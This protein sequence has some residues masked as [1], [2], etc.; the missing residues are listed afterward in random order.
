MNI[1]KIVNDV[2]EFLKNNEDYENMK[3]EYA[4][5][6]KDDSNDIT[7]IACE[8]EEIISIN[9]DTMEIFPVAE[10]AYSFDED[11]LGELES[12]KEIAY[13][14]T[15]YHY[16]IWCGIEQYFPE[17]IEHKEGMQIY[18]Q[19][20][21]DKGITKKYLDEKTNLDTPNIMQHFEGLAFRETMQYKGYTIEAD[22]TNIDNDKENI[23]QIY[24]NEQDYIN[25][26]GREI[27]SLNTVGLKQNIKDY[28]D[29]NYQENNSLD[30]EKA[31]F[32]FVLG[33]DVLQ[34]MFKNS[35]SPECDLVYDFCN[36]EADQFLKSNEYQDLR[37][38]GYE[39]LLEW[40]QNNKEKIMEDFKEMT[41][42]EIEI[43]NGNM[44]II[45]R[46]QR[47]DQPIALVEKSIGNEKEY[48]VAFY[49]KTNGDKL[50]WGYGY[51]YDNDK[52][53]ALE[54]YQ[55]VISGG[56]ITRTFERKDDR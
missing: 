24:D 19:Y 39:M 4:L 6:D 47:K 14:T 42:G 56:S 28:I 9:P 18:L 52:N 25:G 36:Y 44:Q 26:E 31:Y 11:I 37:H 13:M 15:D 32:T 7:V 17:E 23:V 54:D 49:Y 21:A 16:N 43:Y 45:E 50:S 55:K 33:Y 3:V 5:R 29:E 10:W 34:D 48:I 27:V 1:N 8:Y 41:G 20:C 46:G 12:G 2:Q 53:K 30:N 51:Y 22:D 40:A 38:S 35:T